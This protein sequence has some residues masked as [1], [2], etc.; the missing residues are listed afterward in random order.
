MYLM[1]NCLVKHLCAVNLAYG[2]MSEYSHPIKAKR[3]EP[4]IPVTRHMPSSIV[5]F[6]RV[7]YTRGNYRLRDDT[8]HEVK[9]G[10]TTRKTQIYRDS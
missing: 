6:E 10:R 7:L 9:L 2:V 3:K 4:E 1:D 8:I 5:S